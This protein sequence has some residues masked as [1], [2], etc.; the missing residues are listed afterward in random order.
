MRFQR[1]VAGIK[2]TNNRVGNIAL[3]R[4]GA[5]RK[6]EGVVLSLALQL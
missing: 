3:E 4:L 5:G 6:K 1:E 2:E